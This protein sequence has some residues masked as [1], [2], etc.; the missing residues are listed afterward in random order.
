VRNPTILSSSAIDLGDPSAQN[1]RDAVPG[2]HRGGIQVVAWILR[3][4][5]R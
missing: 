3:V 1:T 2:R 4:V 5:I